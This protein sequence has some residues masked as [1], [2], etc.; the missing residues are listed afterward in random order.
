[1]DHSEHEQAA[2]YLARIYGHEP[3][4]T[5]QATQFFGDNTTIASQQH[6]APPSWHDPNT[7]R[8]HD[9]AATSSQARI[10][11]IPLPNPIVAT[12]Y[13]LTSERY[14]DSTGRYDTAG[15]DEMVEPV[16]RDLFSAMEHAFRNRIAR[17]HP[18]RRANRGSELSP[19]QDRSG[20]RYVI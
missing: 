18:Y 17:N 19:R 8:Y 9:T 11:D 16:M 13:T 10:P 4:I 15:E 5:E 14:S 6:P 2:D 1:V 12:P 3:N 20:E 7:L